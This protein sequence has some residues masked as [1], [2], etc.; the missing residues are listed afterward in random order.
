MELGNPSACWLGRSITLF[1]IIEHQRGDEKWIIYIFPTH[2][3]QILTRTHRTLVVLRFLAQFC[4]NQLDDW[5][6]LWK[7]VC[8]PCNIF[9]TKSLHISF[10]WP[11]KDRAEAVFSLKLFPMK[12]SKQ[13]VMTCWWGLHWKPLWS[14][15]CEADPWDGGE[16]ISGN[17]LVPMKMWNKSDLR[18]S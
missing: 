3:L 7:L 15:R 18:T 6:R 11:R 9:H 13:A 12:L 10:Q 14:K 8:K 16:K 2:R 4:S 17:Y 1:R 5:A